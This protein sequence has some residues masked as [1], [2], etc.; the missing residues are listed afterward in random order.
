MDIGSILANNPMIPQPVLLLELLILEIHYSMAL[1]I[2]LSQSEYEGK[3]SEHASV[4]G[5]A[6]SLAVTPDGGRER[7]S[8]ADTQS[9]GLVPQQR[10]PL[11]AQPARLSEGCRYRD[12]KVHARGGMG[13]VFI[14][15]DSM[16]G[17]RVALKRLSL[18]STQARQRFHKESLITG[19]LEHPG[20]VPLYDIGTDADGV[21]YYVMKFVEGTT[22]RDAIKTLHRLNNEMERHLQLVKLLQ[23]FISLCQTIAFAHSRG[24]IHRDI[25]PDNVLLG[26]FGEALIVDWGVATT[27]TAGT[28]GQAAAS[29]PSQYTGLRG[30]DETVEEFAIVGSPPYMSPEAASGIIERVNELSDIYLLGATLYE[31][32]V[33]HAPRRGGSYSELLELA[34]QMDPPPARAISGQIPRALNAICIKAM[35]RQPANRYQTASELGNDVQRYLANEPVSAYRESLIERS[36]RWMARHRKYA[37]IVVVVCLALYSFREAWL[38]ARIGLILKQQAVERE[39]IDDFRHMVDEVILYAASSDTLTDSLPL[40]DHETA[41]LAAHRALAIAEVWGRNL[42]Y[43]QNDSERASVATELYDL[44]VMVNHLRL[45]RPVHPQDFSTIRD[46]LTWASQVHSISSALV[47]LGRKFEDVSG[48]HLGWTMLD[49]PTETPV[50][51]FLRGIS[52]HQSA[53]KSRRDPTLQPAWEPSMTPSSGVHGEVKRDVEESLSEFNQVIK[54]SPQH[55]WAHFQRAQC[56]MTLGKLSEAIEALNT[57]IAIRDRKPWAYSARGQLYALLGDFKAALRDVEYAMELDEGNELIRLHRGTIYRMMGPTRFD[58]AEDDFRRLLVAPSNLIAEAACARSQL[59]VLRGKKA[60]AIEDLD[61]ALQRSPEFVPARELRASL[62]LTFGDFNAGLDDLNGTGSHLVHKGALD[63]KSEDV[64]RQAIFL[65][66]LALRVS[67]R[68]QMLAQAALEKLAMVA[69]LHKTP[70]FYSEQAFVQRIRGNGIGSLN[71]LNW[72]VERFPDE[73]SLYRQRGWLFAEILKDPQAAD[74]DF[75]R[76]LQKDSDDP[77]ANAGAGYA[78]AC[79]GK[80]ELARRLAARALLNGAEDYLVLFHVACIFARLD[81]QSQGGDAKFA[82]TALQR[83]FE[84]W[85]RR[86]RIGLNLPEVIASESALATIRYAPEIQGLLSSEQIEL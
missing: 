37:A 77:D 70:Q 58:D 80:S 60:Q 64:L 25:K 61:L 2:E 12:R 52:L 1:G 46:Q 27:R 26:E 6:F 34:R 36:R 67:G 14:A 85:K 86:G 65:R 38:Q 50:D 4:V 45:S 76:V 29:V 24:V 55:Y 28:E 13:E 69:D 35:A 78:A 23:V 5:Q 84:L 15:S 48:T 42:Q 57:C 43:L 47:E 33:G 40:Y 39:Q 11:L 56:L 72:A 3:F 22:L 8:E 18:N 74:K 16:I 44:L 62:H 79:M 17:R 7:T 81:S 32:L 10:E 54:E 30:I 68:R 71:A 51:H 83:A 41:F 66:N 75:T 63:I 82:C 20:V 9:R 19:Q 73:I 59:N 53:S 21:P 31:I 49:Q